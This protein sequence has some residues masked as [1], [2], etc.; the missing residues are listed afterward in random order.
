MLL[1]AV[2]ARGWE[3]LV[4]G[5][6]TGLGHYSVVS[7]PGDCCFVVMAALSNGCEA[8]ALPYCRFISV[9]SWRAVSLPRLVIGLI[10]AAS[11]SMRADDESNLYGS[12][13]D[14]TIVS[15]GGLL[16]ALERIAGVGG[17]AGA[18]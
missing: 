15:M 11:R 7:T 4:S 13:A 6:R 3:G 1:M 17:G 2:D 8:R 16:S 14:R 9:F 10:V 12:G 5:K 18:G